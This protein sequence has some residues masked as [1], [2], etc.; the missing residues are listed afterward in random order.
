MD[1]EAA[2]SDRLDRRNCRLRVA[3]NSKAAFAQLKAQPHKARNALDRAPNLGL[4]GRAVHGGD[5]ETLAAQ[6]LLRVRGDR[7]GADG[8]AAI[9]AA[10]NT[11]GANG[12]RLDVMGVFV[13]HGSIGN[14]EVGIE[15]RR[16]AN[17]RLR[18]GV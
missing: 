3:V 10:G 5:P 11:G 17:P 8:M 2:V 7:G 1:L 4:L 18:E 14:P 6:G 16:T 9:A 15:S 12:R 13:G